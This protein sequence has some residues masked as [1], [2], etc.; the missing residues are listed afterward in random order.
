[1][2][3]IFVGNLNVSMTENEVRELFE[4]F[5]CVKT[6]T[7]VKDRDT[8]GARGFAFVEMPNDG[9]AERAIER[10]KGTVFGQQTLTINEARPKHQELNGKA[11]IE[12]RERSRQVL[13]TRSHRKHRY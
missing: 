2:K 11:A 7:L 1:M 9:E 13:D 3:N 6:V 5:G 4:A 8:G 10:L 12:R